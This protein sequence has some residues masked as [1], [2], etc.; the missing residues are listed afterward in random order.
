MAGDVEKL[1]H[2]AGVTPLLFPEDLGEQELVRKRGRYHTQLINAEA[3]C[4]I[5]RWEDPCRIW[6]E[7]DLKWEV[8][9]ESRGGRIRAGS[10]GRMI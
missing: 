7:D 2:D 4:W 1:G 9:A 5:Y 10:G 6:R 8:G 3:Q